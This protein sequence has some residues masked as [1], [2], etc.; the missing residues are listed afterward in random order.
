MKALG[1]EGIQSEAASLQGWA[2][3]DDAHSK[4]TAPHGQ[5]RFPSTPM[6][7]DVHPSNPPV[8]VL[9]GK[10][11]AWKMARAFLRVLYLPLGRMSRCE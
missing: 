1:R 4:P 3:K 10:S 2:Q 7:K 9:N 5:G 6:R 11:L 8:F